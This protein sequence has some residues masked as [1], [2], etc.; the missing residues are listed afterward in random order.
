MNDTVVKVAIGT[1]FAF[2]ITEG[3]GVS[4]GGYC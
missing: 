2:S 4:Q 1:P 3:I